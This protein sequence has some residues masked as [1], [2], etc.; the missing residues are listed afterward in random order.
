MS[1]N[2]FAREYDLYDIDSKNVF[3]FVTLFTNTL[4]FQRENAY[5]KYLVTK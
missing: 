5:F 4:R 3:Y 2:I 1:V